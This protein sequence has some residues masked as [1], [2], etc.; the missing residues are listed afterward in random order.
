MYFNNYQDY[1][2]TEVR[3]SLLWEYDTD[4][5]DYESMKL[6]IVQRVI[7]RGRTDDFYAI[8]N[9]YGL[10]EVRN[11]IKKIPYLNDKDITFVCTVFNIEKTEL[12]CYS[13]KQ[14]INQHWN[15]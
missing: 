2:I 15:S 1:N 12:K 8:L 10:D 6:I 11:T 7:E 13:K 3:K 5:V 14:S 4:K 9:R